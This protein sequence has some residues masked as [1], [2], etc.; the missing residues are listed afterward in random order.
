MRFK[1]IARR[2]K[3]TYSKF[4]QLYFKAF[5]KEERRH[6]LTLWIAK[7]LG[8]IDMFALEKDDNFVGLLITA[9]EEDLVW[10]DYLAISTD[11]RG[12][13]LGSEVLDHLKD[14]YE[15]SRI[16][17][18]VETPLNQVDNY[19]QRLKRVEFYKQNGFKPAGL[20]VSCF[21]CDFT[22][23]SYN[24]KIDFKEYKLIN[25]S[26]YGLLTYLKSKISKVEPKPKFNESVYM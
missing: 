17:L 1:R 22:I 12:Q 20:R 23:L 19:H 13:G 2:D 16:F 3:E 10:I 25:F 15:G 5:P 4:K 18:E 21:D 24:G 26:T 11:Y 9:K 6:V 7:K 8:K 14:H